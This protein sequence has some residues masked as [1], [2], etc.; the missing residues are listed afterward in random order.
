MAMAIF[1]S[2]YGTL[3]ATR[4]R[5]SYEESEMLLYKA[6]IMEESGDLEGCL[7]F[8][9]DKETEIV[10]LVS[11]AEKKAELLFLLSRKDE[12]RAVYEKLLEENPE[13]Y[14]Y[15]RGL[16]VGIPS[17]YCSSTFPEATIECIA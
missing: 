4:E 6:M 5:P 8:L 15:H 11:L 16:Q 14:D 1:D 10:D 3:K 12:A 17:S 7:K 2:Y 9:Q 13:N